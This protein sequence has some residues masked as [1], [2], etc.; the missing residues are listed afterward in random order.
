M[1]RLFQKNILTNTPRFYFAAQPSP[2]NTAPA[3]LTPDKIK[4]TLGEEEYN[5]LVQIVKSKEEIEL[6]LHN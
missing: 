6:K 1:I 2:Y 3:Y 4:E 5:R